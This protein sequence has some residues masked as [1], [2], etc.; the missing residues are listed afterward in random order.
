MPVCT[1]CGNEKAAQEFV[2]RS[3]SKTGLHTHCKDCFLE[4]NRLSIEKHHGTDRNRHLK[5]RYGI[6][7]HE[8]DE[9]VRSQGNKCAI[10]LA[11]HPEHVDHDHQTGRVRGVL[12]FNCNRGLGYIG[13]SIKGLFHAADYLAPCLF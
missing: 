9:L 11:P 7:E 3:R 6:E 10:C 5:I 2:K 1:R 8:V 12:C 4:V 13:D